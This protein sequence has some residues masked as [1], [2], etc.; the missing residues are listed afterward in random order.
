MSSKKEILINLIIDDLPS[1]SELE[2]SEIYTHELRFLG[3][4]ALNEITSTSSMAMIENFINTYQS[5]CS[6]STV[7]NYS[8]LLNDFL[9]YCKGCFTLDSVNQ[10]IKSKKWSENT[11]SRNMIVI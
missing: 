9:T 5:N 6:K 4:S 7:Y 1:L 11:T 2:L 3:G 10:Y 8:R